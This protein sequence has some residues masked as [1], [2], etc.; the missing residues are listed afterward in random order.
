[1]CG[2]FGYI[3]TKALDVKNA[4][5]IIKHRGPDAEGF[6]QYFPGSGNLSTNP[7]E[8]SNDFRV[9]LGF[10]RLAIID[11]NEH[12]NQP[13]L[14]ESQQFSITFNGE[15]YNYIEL[16][17]ELE[18]LGVQFRT[19]SDTEV[20]LQAYITW[21][22]ECFERLNGMWAL[23]ILDIK[24][25]KVICSRDRFGIK[26]FFYYTNEKNEIYWASEIKQ[27]FEVGVPKEVNEN[28]IKDFIDKKVLDST[29]ETFFKD[30]HHLAAGS[31][32]EID[33]S[34]ETLNIER[35]KYWELAI[36]PVFT[37]LSYLE[38]KNKFKD[39][40]LDSIR[41]RLRS[42]VPVG[43]CL[44]G[45]LDSSSIVAAAA[46]QFDFLIHTFTSKFDIKQ[47]DESEYV[48]ILAKQYDNIN[49]RFCQLTED[50]F[51]DEIDQV[52]HHQD[53][54]FVSM[55]ILAQW[56]V[57]KL[58]K[59]SGVVVLL[60]GQ[61][62]DELLAGYRKFYAFYLKEK[63][64]N[65]ELHK[66]FPTF[67]HLLFN[68]EFNFFDF[69]QIGRYLNSKP[70][71]NY[72]S[73]K[74]K[75]LKSNAVIGLSASS[76]LRGRS[77]LD[78]ERFSF[79]PLLRYEDRNSMAF[80]IETRVPFMDYRLIEYLYSISADFKIRK[81]YTKAIMRDA[82][83]GILPKAIQKRKS[84][85]GFETPQDVWMSG[86]LSNYFTNYFQ[87]MDNPY[88]D[89]KEIQEAFNGY[90]NNRISS[91]LFF[92]IYCFDKWYQKHFS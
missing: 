15:I 5:D 42:D 76:T 21:G 12:S 43:S 63:L 89:T 83:D 3:G 30:I 74:G 25:R 26:P 2:I 68:K 57:M 72:Y 27:F 92:R 4:T 90:P 59:N 49:T 75:T 14:D 71:F 58:A 16:R 62:G 41:L 10:R 46:H 40:F 44:S 77:K 87:K 64:T 19:E 38:A 55:S 85:L 9:A 34:E 29:D 56:E 52:L 88:F 65:L 66:F 24:K 67:M 81:G 79:P 33:F 45:G 51:L 35:N 7:K 53:E 11:L 13:F 23:S 82:L 22:V 50:L 47:F 73:E 84:K 80:S 6:L 91:E 78:V 1:M 54:P 8:D 61:G 70:S 36:Q 69:Q 37:N 18:G 17:K 86:K 32:M 20:L 48:E 60:D 39:L 28:V 31:Y